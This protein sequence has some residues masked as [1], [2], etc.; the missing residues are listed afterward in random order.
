M[1]KKLLISSAILL[2]SVF[3]CTICFANNGLQDIFA[4]SVRNIVEWC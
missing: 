4:D 1:Y 3:S 2:M